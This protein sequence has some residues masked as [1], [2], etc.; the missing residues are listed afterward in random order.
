MLQLE[1]EFE[2]SLSLYAPVRGG[3][4]APV[5]GRVSRLSLSLYAPVRGRVSRFSL[6]LYAPVR[7]RVSRLSLSLYAP[8]RGRVSQLSLS[9][10]P[11]PTCKSAVA[12]LC[13]HSGLTPTCSPLQTLQIYTNNQCC[14][15]QS[16]EV[17]KP[18]YLSTVAKFPSKISIW[19]QTM[20]N[21]ISHCQ[22]VHY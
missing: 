4:Y 16:A 5:R 2:L 9:L 15:L 6:S 18:L 21:A 1:V 10:S 13:S 7:G 19:K 12:E 3:L 14:N 20:K 8:V 22:D 11:Q 17:S